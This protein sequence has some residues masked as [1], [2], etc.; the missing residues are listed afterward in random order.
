MDMIKKGGRVIVRPDGREID[1]SFINGLEEGG[2]KSIKADGFVRT[3][4]PHCAFFK[5]MHGEGGTELQRTTLYTPEG[6]LHT[7]CETGGADEPQTGKYVTK[8]EHLDIMLFYL[9][10]VE[11]KAVPNKPDEKALCIEM[12]K[13]P[14][15]ELFSFVE[16]ELFL[17]VMADYEIMAKHILNQM[18]RIYNEKLEILSEK[19]AGM[20]EYALFEDIPDMGI[21][22]DLMERWHL[23]YIR[24]ARMLK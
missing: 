2:I 15:A 16:K 12:P 8:P 23:Y 6:R 19:L 21:A 22:E 14:V 20:A 11:V 7:D 1:E 4:H 18:R 3:E 24:K 5:S 13:T 9:R 10:D 17:T